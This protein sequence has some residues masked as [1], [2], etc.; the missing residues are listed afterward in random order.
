ML[1]RKFL[2]EI[3]NLKTLDKGYKLLTE[4]RCRLMVNQEI[5]DLLLDPIDRTMTAIETHPIHRAWLDSQP[6][7]D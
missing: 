5:S 1:S 3:D 4:A 7:E 6:Q 2:N